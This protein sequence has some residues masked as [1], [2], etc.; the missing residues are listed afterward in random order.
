MRL[1]LPHHRLEQ[2]RL[3]TACHQRPAEAHEGRPLRHSLTRREA[4][5]PPEIRPVVERLGQRHV[6]QVVPEPE[7]QRLEQ[8]QRRPRRLP[9]R[10]GMDLV[11]QP[12]KRR[13]V[14]RR[15]D[16]VEP[17][18]PPPLTRRKTE[19]FLTDPP[20]RHTTLPYTPENGI[21]TDPKA[22]EPSAHRSQDFDGTLLI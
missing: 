12:R 5:E 21:T 20:T 16:R 2:R 14:N 22:Q 3:Q 8:R 6:R 19:A 17:G 15:T 13:P 18:I 11:E 1:E 7:Q 4:A 9:L 10:R